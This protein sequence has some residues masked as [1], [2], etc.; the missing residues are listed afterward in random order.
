MEITSQTTNEIKIGSKGGF[1]DYLFILIPISF[2]FLFSPPLFFLLYILPDISQTGVSRIICDRIE[3]QQVDCQVS[4]SKYFDLVRVEPVSIKFVRLA[5]FD[6]SE[7]RNSEKTNTYKHNFQLINKFGKEKTFDG[8]E[9]SAQKTVE[10]INSFLASQQASLKQ[11]VDDRLSPMPMISLVFA[12]AFNLFI[13]FIY[14]IIWLIAQISL[15]ESIAIAL[16]PR[17]S[18]INS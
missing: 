14:F 10:S 17:C 1:K 2:I 12:V 11:T 6:V 4:K 18:K 16:A 8:Y 9:E 15:L 5:K 13:L 7:Y 3:P